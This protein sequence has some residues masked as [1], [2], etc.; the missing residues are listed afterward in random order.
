MIHLCTSLAF[1]IFLVLTTINLY[2]YPAQ[3]ICRQPNFFCRKEQ[4]NFIYI[5]GFEENEGVWGPWRC[6]LELRICT[7][8]SKLL[9]QYNQVIH[10]I[11]S[12][13]Q[14]NDRYFFRA[15]KNY[16]CRLDR[17]YLDEKLGKLLTSGC[18]HG[19]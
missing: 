16:I 13:Q 9:Q 5:T 19:N 12:I 8:I 15:L 1:Y 14:C 4:I 2:F 10:N 3:N 17:K 6:P 18:V 7:L 11:T